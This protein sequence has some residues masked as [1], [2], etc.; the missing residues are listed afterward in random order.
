MDGCSRG[1]ELSFQQFQHDSPSRFI[2][3]RVKHIKNV[4]KPLL[5]QQF[6]ACLRIFF[7]LKNLTNNVQ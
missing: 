2:E 5:S 7:W 1:A 4:G 3:V 6:L